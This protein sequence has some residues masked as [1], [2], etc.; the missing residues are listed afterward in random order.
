MVEKHWRSIA[1]SASWRIIGTIDTIILSWL[2][3]GKI[4]LAFS[5]GFLELFTKCFLFYMHERVW[6][7]V[8]AGKYVKGKGSDIYEI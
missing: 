7:K 1:K 5:I 8:N 4:T 2:V 3:T 6:N